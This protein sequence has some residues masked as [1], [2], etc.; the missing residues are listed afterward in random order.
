MFP[1]FEAGNHDV[2]FSHLFHS[3]ATVDTG[4]DEAF[5]V[6]ADLTSVLCWQ[7]N[8]CCHSYS[9]SGVRVL[10]RQHWVFVKS[11]TCQ[12][13][14]SLDALPRYIS[15]VVVHAAILLR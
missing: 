14:K 11:F 5:A 1:A 7:V 13:E 15:G 10:L 2:R 8:L 3:D 4:Q 6:L 12:A 9:S